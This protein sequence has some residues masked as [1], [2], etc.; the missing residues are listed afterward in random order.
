MDLILEILD[1]AKDKK[2]LAEIHYENKG[3]AVPILV[4][5]V[6]EGTPGSAAGAKTLAY[7]KAPA[8][9]KVTLSEQKTR[10]GATLKKGDEAGYI[11]AVKE[12]TPLTAS[13]SGTIV[14]SV[15]ESGKN[16]GY[17]DPILLVEISEQ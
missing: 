1:W 11:E 10:P 6:F 16:V 7:L 4:H 12:K 9:G 17:G 2:D 8:I 13:F 15:A 14:Q 3:S 5:L